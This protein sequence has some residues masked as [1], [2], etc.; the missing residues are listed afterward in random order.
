MNILFVCALPIELH[1]CK[2]EFQKVKPVLKEKKSKI[3]ASF[4]LSWVGNYATLFELQNYLYQRGVDFIINLWVCGIV[5]GVKIPPVVQIY[6]IKNTSNQ[7]E[8]IVPIYFEFA[9]LISIASSE[10]TI[11]TNEEMCGEQF[12]DMESYAID[13][14]ATKMKI[15]SIILKIPFDFVSA[16]S[17]R[18]DVSEISEQIKKVNF[19]KLLE[20]IETF[21]WK[22]KNKDE[23][24]LEKYYTFFRATFSE[25]EIIKREY[26]RFQA[27][28]IH[29]D[30]F[31]ENNKILP[32]KEFFKRL[33]SANSEL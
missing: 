29:F 20:S 1:S 5:K 31:F 17:K 26:S 11:T 33:Q 28:W 3:K 23:S 32:K 15:P 18:V 6:R 30:A 2:K 27:F 14:I 10:K 24:N 4:L 22:N 8:S 19:E 13:F 12:V 9:P 25:K 7:R 16:E 21:L